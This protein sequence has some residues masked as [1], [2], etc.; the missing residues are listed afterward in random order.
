MRRRAR[1][2]E[3]GAPPAPQVAAQAR[4]RCSRPCR[5]NAGCD[6]GHRRESGTCACRRQTAVPAGP[7]SRA[8]GNGNAERGTH[9]EL[10][11]VYMLEHAFLARCRQKALRAVGNQPTR[12]MGRRSP[13]VVPPFAT[14]SR[15]RQS[16]HGR[17]PILHYG[18]EA[19]TRGLRTHANPCHGRR[20]GPATDRRPARN[21]YAAWDRLWH[22]GERPPT[23]HRRAPRRAQRTSRVRQPRHRTRRRAAGAEEGCFPCPVSTRP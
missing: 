23:G 21:M 18:G 6:H 12:R 14:D 17:L 5:V 16:T 19:P 3:C 9:G 2:D 20:A 7:G 8:T 22:P 4:R 1:D 11:H 10:G 13:Q 15:T